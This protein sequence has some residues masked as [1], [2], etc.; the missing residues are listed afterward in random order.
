MSSSAISVDHLSKRF[1]LTHERNQSLKAALLRGGRHHYEEFWA[2]S[3][4]SFEIPEGSTFGIIGSN[5]SGKST[6]LK[7]M[8]SILRPDKG[9]ITIN[10]SLS[11]LL[12]LGA[13]FHP[14]LSGRDN[15]YLNGAILGLTRADIDAR[16]DAIVGFAEL[17]QFIDQ[18]VKNYSS[19]MY[20]RL[21]FAVAINVEPEILLIDEVLSV[22]DQS[23]QQRCTDKIAELNSDGRT[24]V[25]VS[26]GMNRLREMCDTAIW[27]DRGALREQGNPID[28]ID[29]Y[30][31]DAQSGGR[32][33]ARAELVDARRKADVSVEILDASHLPTDVVDYRGSGT[34]RVR[35]DARDLPA[36]SIV[37]RG[38]YRHDGVHV[39]SFNT[40]GS[41]DFVAKDVVTVDYQVENWP[42][43]AGKYDVSVALHDHTMVE[44]HYRADKAA[45]FQVQA[46]SAVAEHGLVAL[47]GTWTAQTPESWSE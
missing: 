45:S 17:E 5:G 27:L 6:I 7:V 40:R 15:V 46:S 12:E 13:G 36:S 42:L 38:G 41:I 14:E 23:F 35:F 10:G 26:H 30:L 8:A 18:P 39:A 21:G 3:D 16:F 1:R 9:S 20:V 43:Q 24:I 47:G 25:I 28:V 19:G 29:A 11:A 31:L 44:V 33:S 2:L 4:V 32:D 34:I 37:A 22:G